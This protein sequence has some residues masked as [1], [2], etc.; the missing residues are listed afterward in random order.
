VISAWQAL[1]P[2]SD[3]L[4]FQEA[5]RERRRKMKKHFLFYILVVFVFWA[6]SVVTA[7]AQN[8]CTLQ[9]DWISY[10][11]NGVPQWMAS[12]AGQSNSSGTTELEAPAV[13]P[14]LPTPDGP[15]FPDAV[16]MTQLRGAWERTGGDTFD[17]T[18]I[19]YAYDENGIPI[20]ICRLT[21]AITGSGD[22]NSGEVTATLYV[23]QCDS[24]GVCPNPYGETQFVVPQT[25]SNAYRITV[26]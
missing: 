6:A 26:K 22:C 17:Y 20:Y 16:G 23:Y 15:L 11:A 5:Y 2:K 12:V 3:F 24:S 7:A 1:F 25:P 21:G 9:G 4:L 13:F 18:Y 19:G 10:D 8:G 14:T